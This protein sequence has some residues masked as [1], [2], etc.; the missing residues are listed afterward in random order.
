MFTITTT[1]NQADLDQAVRLARA[2]YIEL[3]NKFVRPHGPTR[4]LC[5]VQV[6]TEVRA[7]LNDALYQDI[8][9]DVGAVFA[10]NAQT[11]QVIGFTI[12]LSGLT[13][14][15]CGLNYMVVDVSY[16]RQGVMKA[17]L[18]EIMKNHTF[19]GLSC[20][21]DKVPYYEPLGFRITGVETVQV[22]MSWGVNKPHG[23]MKVIGF[24]GSV[25][26]NQA[27]DAFLR[28][29]AQGPSIL[30]KIGQQQHDRNIVV[31]DY[32]SKRISGV[33]HHLAL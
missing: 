11:G 27:K 17:M 24:D 22:A 16:R 6:E 12:F 23:P 15:D 25:P 30:A 31:R 28:H 20:N 9:T 18:A 14:T 1:F 19:I 3:I 26:I 33:P 2:N 5:Q 7:Y 32:V 29:N 10:K 4:G 21:I 13:P 8:G